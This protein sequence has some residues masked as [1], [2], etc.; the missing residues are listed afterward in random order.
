MSINS[1]ISDELSQKQTQ[2]NTINSELSALRDSSLHQKKRVN[3]M[4]RS[5]LSDLG[6]V[7]TVISKNG[8]ELKK[9]EGER[10]FFPCQDARYFFSSE[11]ALCN[12]FDGACSANSPI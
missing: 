5:L 12:L 9:P 3:E 4:L 10:T 8:S 7:G 11:N 6:E 1:Q 2:L